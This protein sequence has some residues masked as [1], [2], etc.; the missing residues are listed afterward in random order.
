MSA[1]STTHI[2]H[3]VSTY[4]DDVL[5]RQ[6]LGNLSCSL[7]KNFE[8]TLV[9]LSKPT[10]ERLNLP[11]GV[12]CIEL[13]NTR[14]LSWRAFRECGRVLSILKPDVCHTYGNTP[15]AIQW[16]ARRAGVP[17]K[18]HQVSP[19]QASS[20]SS[21]LVKTFLSTLSHSTDVFITASSETKRWL[22]QGVRI[23]P[24][25]CEIIRP[26]ID[27]K[28]FCPT[29][30]EVNPLK[31]N[32]FL[33][34][35]A[36]PT[37]K[38][39]VGTDI[40]EQCIENLITLIDEFA[41]A[42]KLSPEFKTNAM[43]LIAGNARYIPLLRKEVQARNLDEDNVRILGRISNMR[44]FYKTIDALAIPEEIDKNGTQPIEA[45]SMAIPI[46]SLRPRAL[47]RRSEHP[48][49]WTNKNGH[50]RIQHQLLDIFSDMGKRLRLGREARLY[51]QEKHCIKE[52]ESRLLALYLRGNPS[53]NS[54]SAN[55]LRFAS[56][57][58]RN[59]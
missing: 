27:A 34:Q 52:F 42:S 12:S 56:P 29:L 40:S 8:H 21:W 15:L 50:C 58:S 39:V 31:T 57:S 38:F 18:L 51:V 47:T 13:K 7:S 33:G 36:I 17:V 45:M 37:N 25:Q 54:N 41:V 5:N 16:M 22:E 35:I 2:C 14:P 20:H 11:N 59:E 1:A 23:P 55:T 3:I 48:L 44:L 26:A 46:I 10:R 9:V 6:L 24:E 28:H 30:Q 49:K 4:T 43:L 32:S 19:L 53:A